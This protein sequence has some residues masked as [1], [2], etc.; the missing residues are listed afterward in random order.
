MSEKLC[1]NCLYGITDKHYSHCDDSDIDKAGNCEGWELSPLVELKQQLLEAERV[2]SEYE[3]QLKYIHKI[4]LCER[5]ETYGFDYHESHPR[6]DKNNGGSR[7]A[8]P[9][10]FIENSNGYKWS[11]GGRYPKIITFKRAREYEEKHC[12]TSN[13]NDKSCIKAENK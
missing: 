1:S 6:R 12:N 5:F 3:K 13:A 8:T 2:I 10:D 7:P 11:E 4:C 9:R